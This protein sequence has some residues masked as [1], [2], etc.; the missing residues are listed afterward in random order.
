MKRIGYIYSKIYSLDN[1][2]N[3][4]KKAS[5]GKRNQR[6]VK[7]ILENTDYY[8]QQIQDILINKTY[9]PSQPR[10]KEI[11]DSSSG[12]RRTIFKPN[13]YP[14]Q[15]IHRALILQIE[16]I[17]MRGMYIYSCGSVPNRGT[18]Y[19]Q[20][21]VRRW[22][23]RDRKNTK[24]CL[25]MDIKKYYPSINNNVLK[26]MF[27]RKIKDRDCLWLID[28]IVDNN[29]GQPIGYYTSQWFANFFLQG[30]DHY[31]K[32]TL[33][34]K[35]YVRYV[36]DLV[37]FGSNKKRLHQVRRNIEMY[38]NSI[39]LTLK[40]DWQVFRINCRAIDFLGL[41]FFRNKTILRKRNAL[42]I[43]RRVNKIRKKGRLGVKDASALLSYW[44][45]IKRT[46]SF[47]FYHRYVK[48][49]VS[50]KIARKVVSKNAK[51]RNNYRGAIVYNLCTD[52][53]I[54]TSNP[55]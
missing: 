51:L 24:Y 54:Q 40:G 26:K 29:N 18:S 12:K 5:L 25:K 3:A 6:N 21:I 48:P 53:W 52:R 15:I 33:R 44:G 55:R 2:K 7:K 39:D 19:G 30:L 35:Y 46:D 50:I 36:D 20:K 14:D 34:V 42:K 41:R 9:V 31:I 43:K 23:D 8:A 16:P 28:S 22:L 17:I 38:L 27:R 32:E 1:I 37:L 49:Y 45:W 4:I 13:F 10:V 11:Q 47:L